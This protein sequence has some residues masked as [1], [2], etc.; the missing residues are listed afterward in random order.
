MRHVDRGT[1]TGLLVALSSLFAG[2]DVTAP[3]KISDGDL[4]NNNAL[5]ALVV[6][7][8]SRLQTGYDSFGWR[9]AQLFGE[10]AG[11]GFDDWNTG[12]WRGETRPEWSALFDD[13][14]S[15]RWVAEDGIRRMREVLGADF[16]TSAFA[17]EGLLYGGFS[18]RL[19]G[20]NVC[21]AVIDGGPI[22]PRTV[23]F[24]RALDHFTEAIG[25][26]SAIGDA[27]LLNAAY[28]GRASV[29]ANL[30]DWETATADASKVPDDYV[31]TVQ[32]HTSSTLER[33]TFYNEQYV[34]QNSSAAYTYFDTYHQESGDL[35]SP[36]VSPPSSSP[37]LAA[38]GRTPMR[39]QAKY[40]AWGSD[41]PLT[42]GAEMRLIEAEALIRSGNW[43]AG[44]DRINALREAAGLGP[45]S[46][47][48][49]AE[50]IDWLIIERAIVNWLENRRGGDLFR[51]G[52]A[53]EDDPILQAQAALAPEFVNYQLTGR[54]TCLP[55][56]INILQANPN[57]AG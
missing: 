34:R 48:S 14:H 11:A 44:M 24:E 17:A 13:I 3:G 8:H 51:L 33:N 40:A 21:E 2:C 52:L 1:I 7:M 9:T 35:R 28:G 54:A 47:T 53:P 49:Q 39:R 42:K 5:A 12:H 19:L 37:Q 27:E 50:A 43:P 46:A 20:E 56:S 36:V 30:G 38:D 26:A 57:T 15:A 31:F 6:G 32:F 4:D 29:A 55:L 41:I 23:Y 16:A 10:L 18:N 22:Q 25:I 45:R